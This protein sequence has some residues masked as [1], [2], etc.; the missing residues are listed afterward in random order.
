MQTTF[1]VITGCLFVNG[2]DVGSL[3]RSLSFTCRVFGFPGG[4]EFKWSP[5]QNTWM[6]RN[7]VDHNREDFFRAVIQTCSDHHTKV[8]V[9]VSDSDSRT[10]ASC[11]THQEFVTKMLIERVD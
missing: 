3:E 5:R 9:I 8:S 2:D 10:P 7:L 1:S 4:E 6:Y 11:Q